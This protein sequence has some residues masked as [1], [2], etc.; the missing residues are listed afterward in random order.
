MVELD[1]E[2]EEEK[3]RKR[4]KKTVADIVPTSMPPRL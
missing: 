3:L 1:G 2:V 4:N